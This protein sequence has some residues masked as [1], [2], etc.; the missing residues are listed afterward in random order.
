MATQ[1]PLLWWQKDIV[2][3]VYPR[4]FKDTNDNGVGD[5]EGIIQKLDYLKWLG[6]S[7]VWISPVY[8]SPMADFGYDISDYT[9]IHPLFGSM[10]DFDK[11]LKEAHN[12]NIKIIMDLVP[13]HTSDEHPWFVESRS[14]RDNPK[15]DWYIW[16]DPREDGSMPNNWVSEFGGPAWQYDEKT[17]QYYYHTFLKSQPD[18]NWYNPEVREAIW[19]IMRFWLKKGVD[20]FRVDVL[21]YLIK[22]DLFRDNPPNPDWHEGMPEHDKLVATFS[23]DQPYVHDVI[24]EMRRVVDEFHEKVIIGEIY[25]PLG[26]LVTYYSKGKGV[27]LAFNFHLILTEWEAQK[28]YKL[29]SDYEGAVSDKGWPNWVLGN[30]DNSRI[31]S[32]IGK[33]QEWNAGILLL[34]LR[35]TPT[36]YYGDEIGM[37]NVIIPKDKIHDPREINEPGIGVGRDPERTPMQWDNSEFAGFS[38]VEPWLPVGD[39]V[40]E[41]N[42]ERQKDDET[43]LLSFYRKLIKLR[44]SEPAL[45]GGDYFPVGIKDQLICYTRRDGESEFLVALNLGSE[46]ISFKPHFSFS[47]KVE[48]SKESKNDGDEIKDEITLDGNEG[49]VVR[50]HEKMEH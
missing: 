36:M 50:L 13:N 7:A 44:Q 22:D 30:H 21:W 25:L 43:S 29:I 42:V 5:L 12:R 3:Q 39:N 16:K 24:A 4:S 32:R 27:H 41:I 31:K 20:G 38:T 18:L 9:D 45:Y 28:I 17:K 49:I 10:D 40:D 15:R 2:Y 23:N 46:N 47:G 26:K 35:G 48:A 1:E 34:T 33:G 14:S 11:L 37:E 19:N 6:I 8:P